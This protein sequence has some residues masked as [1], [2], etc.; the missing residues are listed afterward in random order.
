[1]TGQ[2]DAGQLQIQE[3]RVLPRPSSLFVF[4]LCT[5]SLEKEKM[6]STSRLLFPIPFPCLVVHLYIDEN[7][8]LS[9][10]CKSHIF[11]SRLLG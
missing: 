4:H 11:S 1:M 9:H 3:G 6:M 5:I 8:C 10:I 2:V 7:E